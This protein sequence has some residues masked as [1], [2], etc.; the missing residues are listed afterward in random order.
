MAAVT[1]GLAKRKDVTLS[2]TAQDAEISGRMRYLFLVH[3]EHF[4]EKPAGP[5]NH[6]RPH[7]I[8]FTDPIVRPND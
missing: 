7:G 5:V 8:C 6:V 3:A 1:V 2:R 4:L